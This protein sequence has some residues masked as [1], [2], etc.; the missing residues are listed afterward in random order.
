MAKNNHFDFMAAANHGYLT[1]WENRDVLLRLAGLPFLIKMGCIAAILFLGMEQDVLRHGLIMLP[2]Y[3]AE[4][5][6]IAYVLR[7]L[8]AGGNL[9]DDVKQ[10]HSYFQ[11][12]VASMVLYVLIKIVLAALIGMT[13]ESL[14]TDFAQTP[15]PEPSSQ[16][17][18]AA[19]MLFAFMIWAFR[20]MWLYVPL[21]MGVP[22]S[23]FLKKI[24]GF[25]VSFPMFSCWLMCFLPLAT[26]TLMLSKVLLL[27]FPQ[28]EGGDNLLSTLVIACFQ[29]CM[30]IGILTVTSLAM[31]QG[32]KTLMDKA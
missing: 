25:G 29:G 27:A 11:D 8:C 24:E 15:Q 4:G 22:L 30:E 26:L 10:A 19:M 32:F 17:F 7:V 12:V 28:V 31:A 2:S 20:F 9:G 5:F 16:A 13:V 18:M 3:F 21:A 14:P 6:L 23:E 1:V